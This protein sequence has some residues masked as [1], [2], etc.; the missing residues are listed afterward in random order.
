MKVVLNIVIIKIL[1]FTTNLNN[2]LHCEEDTQALPNITI[3]LQG[4]C[5]LSVVIVKMG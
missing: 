1:Y 2:E 5:C 3:L 4:P